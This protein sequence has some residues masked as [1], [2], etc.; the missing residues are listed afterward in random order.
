[1]LHQFDHRW[2][3]YESAEET[4]DVT[5]AEKRDLDFVVQPLRDGAGNVNGLLVMG[6]DVTELVRVGGGLA[7]PLP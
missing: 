4:R 3:T 5:A 7:D 6:M 1:M 2:A